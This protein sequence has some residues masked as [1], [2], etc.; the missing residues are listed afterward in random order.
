MTELNNLQNILVADIDPHQE[1]EKSYGGLALYET[2]CHALAVA[3][4]TDEVKDIRDKSEAMR[5]YGHQCKNRQL[6]ID[7]AEIRIRAE[8]RLGELIQ[9]QK[10]TVGLN[11]GAAAGGTKEGPRGSYSEP[12]DERPTLAEVG[13]D[14]KLSSHAQKVASIP[15]E[16]FEGI[17]GEWREA[18][19]TENER[20]TTNIL[21][22]AKKMQANG[23]P[24]VSNNS[25]NNEWYTPPSIVDLARSVMGVIDF[26]PASS[27]V[28]NLT[29]KAS[30]Y[31]TEDMDGLKAQWHGRVWLNPPYSSPLISQFCEAT[32][33]AYTDGKIQEACVL[34][35]NATETRWLQ[36][37][38][39]VASAVC[40]L[41]GRIKFLD[42]DGVA[43]NA[44]LQGQCITYIG[45]NAGRFIDVFS[46]VGRCFS[47]V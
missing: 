42:K 18:L 34:T 46:E 20:V 8:R 16:E 33:A 5:A 11:A 3:K 4:N 23:K 28:A 24:H 13:I 45:K 14:K 6:E 41:K 1:I 12:R 29:V 39:S 25:G 15:D 7:A 36:D 32:V 9:A 21:A 31:V 10:D 22:A 38:F 17:V 47:S 19:E 40:F 43:S 2:A 30:E 26:D 27:D 35:N 44:P 37:L